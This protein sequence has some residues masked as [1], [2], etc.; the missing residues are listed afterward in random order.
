M[1]RVVLACE[2]AAVPGRVFRSL[3]A[4]GGGRL[5]G[6]RCA[7]LRPLQGAV[8]PGGGV[9]MRVGYRVGDVLPRAYGESVQ[10]LNAA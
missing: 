9:P 7:R 10:A 3:V 1:H 2:N 6:L 5:R 4:S 8:V